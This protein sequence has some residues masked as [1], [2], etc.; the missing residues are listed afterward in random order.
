MP[1]P[2][3]CL[4]VIWSGWLVSWLLAA[5]WTAK[6]VARQ[7][8]TSRLAQSGLLWAGAALLFLRPS[9]SGFLTRALY[10]LAAWVGWSGVALSVLGLG[11]TGWA[12]IHL[13]RFWSGAV[14]LKAEHALIR[15]GPYGL[16]RH[17]IYTG[18]LLAMAG[19]ALARNSGC[20]RGRAGAVCCRPGD[21]GSTGG[22][23]PDRALRGSLPSVP[24][25]GP[26]PRPRAL[27]KQHAS[28]PLERSTARTTHHGRARGGS[29]R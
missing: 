19:T 20:G 24:S 6:T 22:G 5:R 7:S 10:P 27:V 21:Q 16:T 25:R 15:S 8:V 4:A 13:G 26:R 29:D 23:P 18:L 17:P 11:F 3:T 14:T 12:R 2:F 9:G 28:K 1:S